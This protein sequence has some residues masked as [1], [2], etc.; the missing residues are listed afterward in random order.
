M[1]VDLTS[2]YF[3][4]IWISSC[5]YMFNLFEKYL[6][7]VEL[8]RRNYS[9]YLEFLSK[10]QMTKISLFI[11][12]NK[13]FYCKFT[14]IMFNLCI[15]IF[16]IHKYS[17]VYYFLYV[18]GESFRT[19]FPIWLPILIQTFKFIPEILKEDFYTFCYR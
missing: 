18:N 6:S 2:S 10:L 11:E 5:S 17:H 16:H 8:C 14:L 7:Q 19:G 9:K 4:L 12:H 13:I 15:L 3:L 1:Q